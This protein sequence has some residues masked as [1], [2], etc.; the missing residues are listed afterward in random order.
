MIYVLDQNYLR[1]EELKNLVVS[2]PTLKFV[3]PDVAM[4]EMCKGH[5]WRETMQ[6]SLE[7]LAKVR[8]RVKQSISVGE[9][10]N[11]ELRNMKSVD[12]QLLRREFT[13]FIRS[14]MLDVKTN[15]DAG[16]GVSLIAVSIEKVQEDIRNAELDHHRNQV[17]LTTRTEI[18]ESALGTTLLKQLKNDKIADDVRLAVIKKV[19]HELVQTFLEKQGYSQNRIKVFL[20]QKPLLLRYFLLS[21]RHAFEWAK[22]GGIGSFPAEKVTNDIL[23]QEY[24][25]I[26]SFFDGILSKENRVN[27][28]DA[29]LR[30][31]LRP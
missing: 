5:K 7:T 23:D 13:N 2:Q 10:L 3:L 1:S 22:N 6:H 27:E 17:S 14:I 16:P 18:I 15:S 11:I 9:A 25:I 24:V 26:A 31:L 4:L 12:G 19:A 20:K 8:G 28:A 30:Q 29:E 21:V